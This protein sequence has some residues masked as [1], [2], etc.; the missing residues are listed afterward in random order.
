LNTTSTTPRVAV[1]GPCGSGKSTLGDKL[2]ELDMDIREIAQEHSYAPDMWRKISNP[3]ILIYLDVSYPVATHRKE[4]D[5]TEIEYSEQLRRLQHA[6]KHC[7]IYIHTDNL[8]PDEILTRILKILD[9]GH[10]PSSD[11]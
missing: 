11:V 8:T 1:V 10:L 5:W 3:D 9:V 4:F 2:R 6:R 7:D